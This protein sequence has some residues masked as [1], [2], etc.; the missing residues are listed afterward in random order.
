MRQ[1]RS[2]DPP[3][4]AE[5]SVPDRVD[6]AMEAMKEAGAHATLDRLGR[7]SECNQLPVRHDAVLSCGQI[8]EVGS[9][10]SHIDGKVRR[11]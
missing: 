3:V 9:F 7:E 11:S 2:H 6:P 10:P 1:N 5:P 4:P 8:R